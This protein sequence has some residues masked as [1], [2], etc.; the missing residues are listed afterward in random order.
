MGSIYTSG[1]CAKKKEEREKGRVRNDRQARRGKCRKAT[2]KARI[3]EVSV[4][5]PVQQTYASIE[6]VLLKSGL[7]V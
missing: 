2:A 6:L 5:I 3:R 1:L 7:V 4:I